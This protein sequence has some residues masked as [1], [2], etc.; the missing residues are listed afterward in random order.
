M[1]RHIVINGGTG[2]GTVTAFLVID[3][4]LSASGVNNPEAWASVLFGFFGPTM[5][6]TAYSDDR[7]P[8]I[9]PN[10]SFENGILS[11]QFTFLYGVERSMYSEFDLVGGFGGDGS[12][13]HTL[14][15]YLDLPE[16]ASLSS[17]SGATYNLGIPPAV[18][19]PESALL[20]LA[21]LGALV[22]IR[23]VRAMVGKRPRS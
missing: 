13:G 14:T 5:S 20:L 4:S 15:L 21:G 11:A 23:R 6:W 7:P 3:G 17:A 10:A 19:E 9:S 1:G 2:S 22:G 16:G 12:F 8:T 18:P